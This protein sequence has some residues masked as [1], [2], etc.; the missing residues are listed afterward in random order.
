MR[1]CIT[2]TRASQRSRATPATRRSL[3]SDGPSSCSRGSARTRAE[4]TT[5][6]PYATTHGSRRLFAER[7]RIGLD[8]LR[9]GKCT[10]P[11][12][13]LLTHEVR[14]DCQLLVTV[15]RNVEHPEDQV[16]AVPRLEQDALAPVRRVAHRV[17]AGDGD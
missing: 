6:R 12:A 17:G 16:R 1:A 2:T 4:T 15:G 3:T 5:S 10:L 8:E 11:A 9:L 14:L 13:A 7:V